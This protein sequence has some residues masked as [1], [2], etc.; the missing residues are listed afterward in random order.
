M[1]AFAEFGVTTNFTFLTGASHPE[2]MVA[3]AA[4]LGL[5]GLGVADT[6]TLAGVVRA[7][8]AMRET[9]AG[10][11]GL[12]L[13]VGARLAFADG[14]PDILAYPTDRAGWGRLSRLITLGKRRAEKGGCI[15]M[16]ADLLVALEDH[17]RG[18]TSPSCRRAA[19]PPRR[20]RR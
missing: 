20:R 10:K 1:T 4:R 6:N 15:L 18:S 11:S 8:V 7:H 17:P 13:A 9:E 16:L 12:R 19:S 5:A 14:A 2:E 3:E